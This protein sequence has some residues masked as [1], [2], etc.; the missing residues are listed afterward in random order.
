MILN[1]ICTKE[2]IMK[3]NNGRDVV[4]SLIAA[5]NNK[6][7]EALDKVF[8][9]DVIFEWPQ[10]G[11]R[12]NGNQNRREIYNRFPS[13]PAIKPNRLDGRDDLWILEAEL[14]YG[15]DDKYQCVFIF[16]IK[17]G[18]ISKETAYWTKPFPAPEWRKPW[19]ENFQFQTY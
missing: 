10:S 11:E 2:I 8:S 5:I 17:N 18:V 13:L 14:D 4:N 1:R 3:I 7:L 15:D 6:D 12:I 19:V 9:G 16:E